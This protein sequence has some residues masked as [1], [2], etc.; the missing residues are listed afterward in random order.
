L[1]AAILYI[2]EV[3]NKGVEKAMKDNPSIEAA[4]NTHNGKLLHLVRLS[5]Q[6]Q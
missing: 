6:E 4:V 3:A 2:M 5:A 1:N